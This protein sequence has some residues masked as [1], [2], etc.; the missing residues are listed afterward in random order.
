MRYQNFLVK[1]YAHLIFA[2]LIIGAI[3]FNYEEE[4][5]IKKI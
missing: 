2:G 5:E 1:Y 4:K 3:Y